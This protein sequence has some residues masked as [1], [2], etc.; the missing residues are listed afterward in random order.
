MA[1]AA[2]GTADAT[3][4]RATTALIAQAIYFLAAAAIWAY[5][6][7]IGR[8][9]GLSM[10]QVGVALAASAFAGMAGAGA[11]IIIG[12][13]LPR[14]LSIAVGTV[15]SIGTVLLLARGTGYPILPGSACL[16]N[17]AWNYTFPYQMGV[18]ARA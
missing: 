12:A 8:D 9:F 14:I 16:F 18:L 7:A 10:A 17:F 15:T 1:T 2:P 3:A 11:V 4:L 13:R 6:E 5:S